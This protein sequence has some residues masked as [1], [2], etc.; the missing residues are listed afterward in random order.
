MLLAGRKR[1]VSNPAQCIAGVEQIIRGAR[2]VPVRSES[3]RRL[4]IL[5]LFGINIPKYT[6]MYHSTELHEADAMCRRASQY[7]RNHP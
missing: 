2:H 6:G 3:N 7:V 5:F 1:R 4:F